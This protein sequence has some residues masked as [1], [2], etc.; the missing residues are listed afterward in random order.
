MKFV[1]TLSKYFIL[2]AILSIMLPLVPLSV[3]KVQANHINCTNWHGD[4]DADCDGLSDAW[5]LI[6]RYTE[7]GTGINVALPGADPNHKDIYVEIDYMS[8]HI[9]PTTVYRSRYC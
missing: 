7:D 6:D 4:F 5:E 8:H 1:P 2:V 9:P 3:N